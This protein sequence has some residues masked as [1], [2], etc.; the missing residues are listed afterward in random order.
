NFINV[1][2]AFGEDKFR[3]LYNIRT[4][5]QIYVLDKDKNIRFKKIG[6][7]DI[8]NTVQYLLEEQGV[9]EATELSKPINSSEDSESLD[10]E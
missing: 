9:V 7:K 6:A 4:T 5:P 10:I 8:P 1:A 3:N 2:N